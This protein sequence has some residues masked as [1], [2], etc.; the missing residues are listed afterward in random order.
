VRRSPLFRQ[1]CGD[2][3]GGSGR[4][5]IIA[6]NLRC[7]H[8]HDFKEPIERLIDPTCWEQAAQAATEL[9]QTELSEKTAYAALLELLAR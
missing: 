2:N 5:A 7:D 3:S 8:L 6:G 1:A 9:A 4:F